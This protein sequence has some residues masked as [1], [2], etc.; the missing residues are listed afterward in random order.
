MN[1]AYI[2]KQAI[3]IILG[4]LLK[5][6]CIHSPDDMA[7]DGF[8][9]PNKPALEEFQKSLAELANSHFWNALSINDVQGVVDFCHTVGREVHHIWS[10]GSTMGTW[11]NRFCEL[12][13]I[14]KVLKID[15]FELIERGTNFQSY[16]ETYKLVSYGRPWKTWLAVTLGAPAR[17]GWDNFENTI[18]YD[19]LVCLRA[20]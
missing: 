16:G 14:Q 20:K 13:Q 7:R 1:T 12:R 8:M 5:D 11:G 4:D 17:W 2:R 15:D 3:A 10:D 18:S 9:E 6:A 19:D